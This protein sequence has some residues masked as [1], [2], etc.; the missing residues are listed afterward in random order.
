MTDAVI[1]E[2]MAVGVTAAGAM[3]WLALGG[4]S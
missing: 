4:W 1:I 3:L 2:F